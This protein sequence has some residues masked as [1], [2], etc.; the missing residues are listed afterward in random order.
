MKLWP[1]LRDGNW[2]EDALADPDAVSYFRRAF[3]QTYMGQNSSW[4]YRA[5]F[6]SL[7][8]NKVNILPSVNLVQNIGIGADA[9]HTRTGPAHSA[10]PADSIAFPLLHPDHMIVD[11]RADRATFIKLNG[12]SG[13]TLRRLAKSTLRRMNIDV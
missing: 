8:Q 4:A 7:A 2:L 12:G 3:D 1:T 5:S 6:S 10:P 13:S 11:R 9:T